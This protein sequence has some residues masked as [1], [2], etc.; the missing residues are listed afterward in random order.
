LEVVHVLEHDRRYRNLQPKGEPQLGRRGLYGH[1]GGGDDGRE[2]ELAILWVLNL[3]DGDH[4]LLD[5]CERS[6]M[7]FG[8]VLE[9]ARALREAGLLEP[10]GGR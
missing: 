3:S 5:V 8:R 7:D 4:S 9:A 2:R 1:I 10:A 6:G